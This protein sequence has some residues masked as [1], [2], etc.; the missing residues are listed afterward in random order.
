MLISDN[1]RIRFGDLIEPG[2]VLEPLP[3][4]AR[5]GLEHAL[6]ALLRGLGNETYCLSVKHDAPPF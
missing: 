6:H 2:K 3:Q 5:S 4:P 1:E